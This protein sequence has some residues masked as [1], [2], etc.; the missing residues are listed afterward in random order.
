MATVETVEKIH[1]KYRK[2]TPSIFAWFFTCIF[3]LLVYFWS[4]GRPTKN[5][6]KNTVG[7][8]TKMLRWNGPKR[9]S[10]MC[11]CTLAIVFTRIPDSYCL[12]VC[13]RACT[14]VHTLK[15]LMS[16]MSSKCRRLRTYL[17]AGYLSAIGILLLESSTV[18]LANAS[19]SVK[20]RPCQ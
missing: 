6:P 13:A 4:V 5:T 14:I 15:M 3:F 1:Q 12:S 2:K 10:R 7:K 9:V 11:C 20:A 18:L 19:L 8:Y 16:L 17:C